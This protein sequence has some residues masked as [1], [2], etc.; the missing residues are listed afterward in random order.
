[1]VD[2]VITSVSQR[3]STLTQKVKRRRGPSKID[4]LLWSLLDFGGT[5]EETTDR[6]YSTNRTLDS[7]ES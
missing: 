5:S 1:M 2:S 4:L 3:D 7:K 6:L